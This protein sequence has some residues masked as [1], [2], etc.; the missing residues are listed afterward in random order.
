[1][2]SNHH[3][4]T[5]YIL[6][7]QLSCSIALLFTNHDHRLSYCKSY[8]D[9]TSSCRWLVITGHRHSQ[10]WCHLDPSQVLSVIHAVVWV[11]GGRGWGINKHY[12]SFDLERYTLLIHPLLSFTDVLMIL[13]IINLSVNANFWFENRQ[14]RSC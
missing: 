3:I 14:F 4:F 13:L 10:R 12:E 9:L 7:M 11:Y 8:L 5:H 2:A 6:Y 1:M